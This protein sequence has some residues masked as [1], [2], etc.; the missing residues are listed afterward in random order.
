MTKKRKRTK[1]FRDVVFNLKRPHSRLSVKSHLHQIVAA[2]AKEEEEQQSRE[3][4]IRYATDL[5]KRRDFKSLV[6]SEENPETEEKQEP[7]NTFEDL[8]EEKLR[9]LDDQIQ[10][11]HRRFFE[12]SEDE[13]EEIKVR[14]QSPGRE[15]DLPGAES[16]KTTTTFDASVH[17][18]LF[19]MFDM[20]DDDYRRLLSA[21]RNTQRELNRQ[22]EEQKPPLENEVT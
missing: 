10:R 12:E 8:D 7:Q 17:A 14:P 4:V 16:S 6:T 1:S 13:D 11:Q 5:V 18:S 15:Y 9:L 22:Q 19:R 21:A 3:S 20:K 2:E